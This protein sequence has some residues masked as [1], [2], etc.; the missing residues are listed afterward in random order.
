[1][2]LVGIPGI[3]DI[4]IPDL[5]FGDY[6]NALYKLAIS[7]AA[8]FAVF[9]IVIAGVKYMLDDI[10]THKQEA[11]ADIRGALVG[12]LVILAAYIILNTINTDITKNQIAVNPPEDGFATSTYEEDLARGLAACPDYD[13]SL[14]QRCVTVDMSQADCEKLAGNSSIYFYVH[15]LVVPGAQST[16]TYVKT[17]SP[18]E[19]VDM[20]MT[21]SST[22][23]KLNCEVTEDYKYIPAGVGFCNQGFCSVGTP[24]HCDYIGN[25]TLSASE[26]TQLQAKVC[27]NTANHVAGY[28]CRVEICKVAADACNAWCTNENQNTMKLNYSGYDSQFNACYTEIH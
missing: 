1:M 15:W 28:T 26:N 24:A 18:G 2:S 13:A 20:V 6:I 17:Y 12:L 21:G 14:G 9:K 11:K 7:I 8:L 10:V 25:Q 23:D 19:P 3:P 27:P 4:E 5:E 22:K 16:C